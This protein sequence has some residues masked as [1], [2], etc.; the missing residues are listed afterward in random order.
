VLKRW[1][2]APPVPRS[3]LDRFPSLSPLL[4][5]VLF[6]R[7]VHDA[8]EV[9]DFLEGRPIVGDP[10]A[11]ADMDRAVDVL[12]RA[13]VN[14]VPIAVY[15]DFDTDGVTATALLVQTLTAMGA[16]VRPY[17]PK[18]VDEGYGLNLNALR[19]LYRKGVRTVVT[20]DC[21]I[22]ALEEVDQAR[23]AME[24]VITDHHTVG[25]SLPRASAV[26]DPKRTDSAYAFRELAGVGVALKLAQAL[27][28]E[29]PQSGIQAHIE[30][31]SLLDLFALGTVADLAPLA[32][33]NR[34][35]VLQGLAV[36]NEA[37]REGV[38]ALL[39]AVRI[40]PG[41]VSA[42]T[43]GF[44][45]GPRLNAAGRLGDAFLSYKLLVTADPDEA[46]R[47]A[48]HL[49]EQNRHRQTL[50]AATYAQAEQM[51]LENGESGSLL[52]AA[53]PSFNSG[54]VGLVAGRLTDTYYRPSVVVQTGD[55]F[56][57][58]SCRSIKEFHI[59]AALDECRDLLVRHGGHAA[60]AGFTTKME[61]L[62]PLM[63]H[64]L[65]IAQRE[66]GGK[67]LVPV[68]AID[69][70]V[71]LSEMNWAT[72][73]WL[74]K[75]EP[76]GEQNPVP[77]FLSHNVLL[78][79][80]RPVGAEGQ[81][82]KLTLATGNGDLDAIAFRFGDRAGDLG[83]RLDIVYTLETNEWN[84]EAKLQLNVQDI[85]NAATDPVDAATVLDVS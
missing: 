15:G 75:L 36:L 34:Y 49:D 77:L 5:Q 72:V 41:D 55:E 76:C 64:L 27:L 81:H 67:D 17:I 83:E 60:A 2:V 70:D 9:R 53:H 57:K 12:I 54:I 61:N 78:R 66:L 45:L 20:V 56:C 18:R 24:F 68:L 44:G 6:N 22:R 52:F 13:I 33:E 21:G 47:L 14:K 51:A 26:I 85:R 79:Q 69:A 35:L 25:P 7:N 48:L 59:T 1:E 58:G 39:Q 74:Q 43:I 73:E 16:D 40:R 10:F 28:I 4:V 29:A 37:R 63:D 62:E 8:A 38:R 19:D 71:P 23:R 3:Y 32:G 82:L 50:T 84:G 46:K 42:S 80:S 65:R 30:E 31:R 11:L